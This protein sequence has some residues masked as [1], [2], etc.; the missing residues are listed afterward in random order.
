MSDYARRFTAAM[1]EVTAAGIPEE[2]A[3]TFTVQA[4]RRLGLRPR[5]IP[6]AS[7]SQTL[8]SGGAVGLAWGAVVWVT[9]T[10]F[11]S[12]DSATILVTTMVLI[13]AVIGTAITLGQRRSARR[14]YNLSRWEDL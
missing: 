14:E 8:L 6:Y 3:V 4:A 10:S 11:V 1:A 2:E 7:L 5:P 13:M 9:L 12:S